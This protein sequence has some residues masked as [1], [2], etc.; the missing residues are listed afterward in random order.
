MSNTLYD[1]IITKIEL[2]KT[3]IEKF[4]MYENGN[5]NGNGNINYMEKLNTFLDDINILIASSE[6]LFDLYLENINENNL[7][8]QDKNR[9]KDHMIAKKTYEFFAPYILQMQIFLKNA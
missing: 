2:L 5:G 9:L 1:N 4:K 7:N 8:N 6:D 3:N